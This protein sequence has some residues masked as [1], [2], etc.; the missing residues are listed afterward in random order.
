MADLPG[1]AEPVWTQLLKDLRRGTYM[2]RTATEGRND[3]VTEVNR[4]LTSQDKRN[5]A[6]MGLTKWE[7]HT[8]E[9]LDMLKIWAPYSGLSHRLH[10]FYL[11]L[12][13]IAKVLSK[14]YWSYGYILTV[15]TYFVSSQEKLFRDLRNP[16]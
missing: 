13:N 1:C 6:Y 2:L 12:L 15:S 3:Y 16:S 9:Y 10:K 4:V 5:R 11:E 14:V 7:R 8:R